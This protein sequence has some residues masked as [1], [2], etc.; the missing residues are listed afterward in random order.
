MDGLQGSALFDSMLSEDGDSD[1]I[2]LL[3]GVADMLDK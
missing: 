1:K 3:P 2:S